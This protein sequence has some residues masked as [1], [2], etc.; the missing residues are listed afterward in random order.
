[1]GVTLGVVNS[2]TGVGVF[3]GPM[4][5]GGLLEKAGYWQAWASTIAVVRLLVLCVK[6][7]AVAVLIYERAIASS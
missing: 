7:E 6:I 4:I 1:M 5:A 2:F 3:A